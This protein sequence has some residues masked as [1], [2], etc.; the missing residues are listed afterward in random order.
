R[1]ATKLLQLA[2][3]L[4][5]ATMVEVGDPSEQIIAIARQRGVR[6]IVLSSQGHSAARPGGFGSVVS[7][8]VRTSPVPTIVARPDGPAANVATFSRVV[9]AHDGSESAAGAL[10]IAQHLASR[11]AAGVHIVTVV[12]DEQ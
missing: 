4:K 8:V 12:E 11:H 3:D 10:P 7:R 5:I 6:A 9:V 1:G 2:P